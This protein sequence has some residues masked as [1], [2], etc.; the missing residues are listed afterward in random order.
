[1]NRAGIRIGVGARFCYEGE[2]VEIVEMHVTGSVL[3]A[4]AK[5]RRGETARRFSLEE[6]L[7]SERAQLIAP[8]DGPAPD[9]EPDIASVVLS[10]VPEAH[11]RLALERAAHV[12]EVLTGYRSGTA[13]APLPGEPR[14]EYRPELPMGQ[15]IA[16]KTR[17]LLKTGE[18][19]GGYR[20]IE[21]WVAQY[22]ANGEAGLVPQRAVQPWIGSR[23]DP[24]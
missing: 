15:R 20:S 2:I 13:Q 8:G 6:L 18:L 7:M 22:R 23:M 21:R 19:K 1:M 9:D 5:D 12:R 16:A 3:E 14:A 11:R 10:A 17:E 4:V 24:R